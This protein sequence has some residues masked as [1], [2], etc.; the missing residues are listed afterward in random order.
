MEN[1]CW[2]DISELL[3]NNTTEIGILE[4]KNK[5]WLAAFI[6]T[7]TILFD[8]LNYGR[9]ENFNEINLNNK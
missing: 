3:E 2:I 5:L 4:F 8:I 6:F 7:Y 1:W 9:L